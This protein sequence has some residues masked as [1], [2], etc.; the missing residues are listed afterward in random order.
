VL[1]GIGSLSKANLRFAGLD[2]SALLG[3]PLEVL[4]LSGTVTPEGAHLHA[5]VSRSSGEVIGG[6]VA[7]GCVVRTTAEILL[8]CLPDWEL[9]REHDAI[10]GYPELRLARH[11]NDRN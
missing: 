1:C 5:S 9:G 7:Y 8:A 6:H 11:E 3:E 2:S 10:S 4:S